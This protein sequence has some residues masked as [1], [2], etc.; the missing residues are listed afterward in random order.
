M[1]KTK[2]NTLLDFI[3]DSEFD[4]N[5]FRGLDI[6]NSETSDFVITL[7]GSPL[8]FKIITNED[9]FNAHATIFTAYSSGY[10]S[11]RWPAGHNLYSTK[12]ED[13][14]DKLS[15]W[16]HTHV[17]PY[18]NESNTP[19]LWK[20][21]TDHAPSDVDPLSVID[22]EK[23]TEGEKQEIKQRLD[24]FR[25]ELLG[26]FADDAIQTEAIN[27]KLDYL[28]T[29]VDRLN[30]TDWRGLAFSVL[31][32][33]G[34]ALNIDTNTGDELNQWISEISKPVIQLLTKK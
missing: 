22:H 23:F 25:S 5:S 15:V 16:L 10:P 13:V 4:L 29:R 24:V 21:L 2:K 17:R 34:I 1:Q 11:Y 18:L 31:M 6:E 7:V 9:N 8:T 19:D 30:R 14:V 3:K 26:K 32:S 20:E 28:K 33:L 27:Q 12:W